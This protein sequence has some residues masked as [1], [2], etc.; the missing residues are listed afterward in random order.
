MSEIESNNQREMSLQEWCDKLPSFHRVNRELADLRKHNAD[1]VREANLAM[2]DEAREW[3]RSRSEHYA[4]LGLGCGGNN[5]AD[6]E[7][8]R[9][10]SM[11]DNLRK[12]LDQ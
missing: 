3:V 12:G 1:L 10:M 5:C 9:V 4:G 2:L 6:C 11:L 8:G 7:L